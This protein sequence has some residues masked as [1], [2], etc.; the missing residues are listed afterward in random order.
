M[1]AATNHNPLVF[2]TEV[3]MVGLEAMF[4]D[5]SPFELAVEASFDAVLGHI[6]DMRNSNSARGRLAL[7]RHMNARRRLPKPY[8]WDVHYRGEWMREVIAEVC[9]EQQGQV[10][11]KF[12]CL[13]LRINLDA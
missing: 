2:M 6:P 9:L 5:G 13:T 7:N 8:Y 1:V 11:S 12:N 10:H 3:R 4:Y